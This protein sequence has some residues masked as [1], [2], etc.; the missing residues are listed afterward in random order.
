M[1]R[2]EYEILAEIFSDPDLA[3][4]DEIE[5]ELEDEGFDYEQFRQRVLDKIKDI[6]RELIY[7]ESKTKI[8]KYKD[9]II[10]IKDKLNIEL[11]DDKLEKQLQLQFNKLEALTEEDILDIL[12]DEKKL[13]YLKE[14][15]DTKSE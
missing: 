15:I 7:Q 13:K 3:T 10:S 11:N 5:K 6:K 9:L 4:T 1:K 12:N 8:K 14:I 2:R